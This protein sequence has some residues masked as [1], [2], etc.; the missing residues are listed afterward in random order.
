MTF[1]RQEFRNQTLTLQQS[2]KY[3]S[4]ASKPQAEQTCPLGVSL[5]FHQTGFEHI[6]VKYQYFLGGYPTISCRKPISRPFPSFS[7]QNYNF[8]IDLHVITQ[9]QTCSFRP[10]HDPYVLP[11]PQKFLL[12][13]QTQF[14]CPSRTQGR[15]CSHCSGL[16]PAS[17]LKLHHTPFPHQNCRSH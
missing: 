12:P 7:A 2:G 5:P 9:W 14:C 17:K 6:T 16:S 10:G 3:L 4:T 15:G 8:Q 1:N 11:F 13:D